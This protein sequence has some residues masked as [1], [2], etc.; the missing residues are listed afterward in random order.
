MAKG[1]EAELSAS[2]P[3]TLDDSSS[4]S[5]DEGGEL[6]VKQH[7]LEKESPDFYWRNE[8]NDPHIDRMRQIRQDHPEVT[9]LFGP[10]TTSKYRLI[11]AYLIQF[12]SLELLMGAPW[13]VWCFCCYT[14][15]ASINTSLPLAFHEWSHNL[16][17]KTQWHNRVL[18]IV[19]NLPMAIPAASTFKRYH[20]EH[21]KFMGEDV[22]DVD[23][24]TKLEGDIFHHNP[25][26]KMIWLFFQPLWYS[27]RPLFLNPK[28]ITMWELANYAASVTFDLLVYSRYGLSGLAYLAIGAL[29]GM[30]FNPIA[31][32]FVAEHF[33][34][35]EDQETYSYYGP[36][37]WWTLNV[38]YHNEHH[39]FPYVSGKN[40]PELRK[41][42]AEYYDDIP[43]YH[44]W[45]KVMV[46]FVMD[47]HLSPFSRIKRAMMLDSEVEELRARGGIV[48]R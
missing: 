41:L 9:S 11:G 5:S 40:L 25:V 31:G 47:P 14:L 1:G 35:N 18:A 27:L 21:H 10:D 43:H 7:K 26:V 36:L 12:I 2:P 4:M 39:D 37:N 6:K 8:W 30:Q 3:P 42:A 13:Y 24:P 16:A 48:P 34:M 20:M 33:I 15:C 28:N 17:A 45:T 23:I 38:G 32:H 44:S 46:D 29:V 22:L 19:A